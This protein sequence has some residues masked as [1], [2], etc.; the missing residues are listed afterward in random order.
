MN[1]LEKKKREAEIARIQA[2]KLGMECQIEERLDE[3]ERLKENIKAQD[4]RVAE[5]KEEMA[6]AEAESNS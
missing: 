4:E 6:K 5:L 1:R 2:A 3:I